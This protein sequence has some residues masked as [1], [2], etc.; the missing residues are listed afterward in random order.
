MVAEERNI[1]NSFNFN[2]FCTYLIN[3]QLDLPE[4]EEQYFLSRES[5]EKKTK[6]V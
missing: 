6:C 2:F 4:P 1:D 5:R 3:T